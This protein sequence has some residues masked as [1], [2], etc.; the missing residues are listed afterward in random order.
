M[1]DIEPIIYKEQ[2]GFHIFALPDAED[3]DG[4]NVIINIEFEETLNF[5]IWYPDS[6]VIVFTVDSNVSP[7]VDYGFTIKL[8]DGT[9]FSF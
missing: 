9:G 7:G 6:K 4:D 2:S 1:S 3:K 8:G 5:G